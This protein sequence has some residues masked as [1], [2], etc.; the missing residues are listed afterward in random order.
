MATE[1][2]IL[3]IDEKGAVVVQ[4]N[5][6]NIGKSAQGAG[7]AVQ[8]LKRALGALA[9]AVVVKQLIGL[10]DTFTVLQNKLKIVTTGTE[11]LGA[12][13]DEL[14]AIARR[15]RS[16][17]PRRPRRARFWPAAPWPDRAEPEGF[18]P[19]GSAPGAS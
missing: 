9:A 17:G 2:L 7:G 4:R 18:R 11:N 16:S 1:R 14:F 13:T 5:V 3:K 19:W 15:T 8:L 6:D 12:V 10:A